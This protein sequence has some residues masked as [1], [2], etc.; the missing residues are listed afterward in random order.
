MK[1]MQSMGLKTHKDGQQTYDFSTMYTQLNLD[2]VK[3]KMKMCT[4]LIFEYAKQNGNAVAKRGKSKAHYYLGIKEL[5][6][7]LGDCL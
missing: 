1:W 4:K 6:E 7:N 5:L 3:R 2:A